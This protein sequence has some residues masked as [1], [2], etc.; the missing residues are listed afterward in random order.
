[1]YRLIGDYAKGDQYLGFSFATHTIMLLAVAWL[2][3]WIAGFVI[4]PTH[5][6]AAQ[7]GQQRGIE[8]FLD[9]K[10]SEIT[11]AL[12]SLDDDRNQLITDA[13]DV[14]N[15]LPENL[16]QVVEQQ[17][18]QKSTDTTNSGTLSRVLVAKDSS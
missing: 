12:H 11:T 2:I 10:A 16:R 3:P 14:L 9:Q 15:V 6:R 1:M 7:V 5:E 4:R 8:N 18:P 13:S 17:T